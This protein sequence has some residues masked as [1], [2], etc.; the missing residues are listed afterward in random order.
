MRVEKMV[1]FYTSR[2][3]AINEPLV[4]AG[5]AVVD[6]PTFAEALDLEGVE[7]GDASGRRDG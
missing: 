2:D 1:A 6:Y 7:A 5:K 3:N 4:N